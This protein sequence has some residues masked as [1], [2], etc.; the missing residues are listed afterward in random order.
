[1]RIYIKLPCLT[2]ME[3][4]QFCHLFTQYL[5]LKQQS[6]CSYKVIIDHDA[7]TVFWRGYSYRTGDRRIIFL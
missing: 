3:Q 1:M 7:A 2:L 6:S 4:C 5:Y